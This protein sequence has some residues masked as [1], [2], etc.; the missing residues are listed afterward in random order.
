MPWRA[1]PSELIAVEVAVPRPVPGTYTYEAP[2]ALL[3][4]PSWAFVDTWSRLRV[5]TSSGSS[6]SSATTVIGIH[7]SVSPAGK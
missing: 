6:R 3:A 7:A 5:K 2:R 4:V 1:V